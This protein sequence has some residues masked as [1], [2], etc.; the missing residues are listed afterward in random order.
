VAELATA[1]MSRL[2][3]AVRPTILASTINRQLVDLCG[4]ST[5]CHLLSGYR[6]LPWRL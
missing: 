4:M 5:L 1:L 6:R 2:P 3:S